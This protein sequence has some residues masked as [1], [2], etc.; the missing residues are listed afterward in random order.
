MCRS[1]RRGK[2]GLWCCNASWKHTH[3]K[4]QPQTSK[5]DRAEKARTL[6][7]HIH[8]SIHF[9]ENSPQLLIRFE[10]SLVSSRERVQSVSLHNY[11]VTLQGV[12]FPPLWLCECVGV[13]RVETHT[14]TH[15]HTNAR[16]VCL[17]CTA[18]TRST[19]S[20]RNYTFSLRACF[21]LTFICLG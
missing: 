11:T 18:H 19:A 13:V 21:S 10:E 9:T 5:A 3:K 7:F 2:V 4:N 16:E 1:V 20:C 8:I 12:F 15:T 17:Y 6:I 14:H